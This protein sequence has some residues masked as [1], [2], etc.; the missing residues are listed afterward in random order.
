MGGSKS[1]DG[2]KSIC[3]N[4]L[5]ARGSFDRGAGG[6]DYG[7]IS[8]SALSSGQVREYHC[9]KSCEEAVIR[10]MGVREYLEM[11]L[12]GLVFWLCGKLKQLY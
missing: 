11:S 2:S 9:D 3:A 1:S 6:H 4:H 5:K 12:R 7:G 10:G 8:G